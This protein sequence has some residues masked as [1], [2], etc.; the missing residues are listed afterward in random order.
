MDGSTLVVTAP[1][2]GLVGELKQTIGGACGM[3]VDLIELFVEG[4]EDALPNGARLD[5]VAVLDGTV[6]FMLPKQGAGGVGGSR[7]SAA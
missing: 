1:Q 5:S 2:R 3:R 6:V 4:G 7:A